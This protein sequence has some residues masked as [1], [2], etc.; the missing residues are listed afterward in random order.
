MKTLKLI[1]LILLFI[2]TAGLL[3]NEFLLHWGRAATLT[4]A[5]ISSIGFANLAIAYLW[6]QKIDD[7]KNI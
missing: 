3:M 6:N 5:G 4:F 7:A 1:A 2:G